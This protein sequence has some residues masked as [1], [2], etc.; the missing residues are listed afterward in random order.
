MGLHKVQDRFLKRKKKQIFKNCDHDRGFCNCR[1]K[2]H[3][4]IKKVKANI[5]KQYLELTWK[6]LDHPQIQQDKKNIK[7]Y[8]KNIEKFY[9]RGFGI[10]LHGQPGLG[11]TTLGTFILGAAIKKGFEVHYIEFQEALDLYTAKWNKSGIEKE[12][13]ENKFNKKI[14]YRDFLLLDNLGRETRTKINLKAL[15][16]IIRFR[17]NNGLPTIFTSNLSIKKFCNRY[18]N[19]YKNNNG[20]V[21][22]SLLSSSVKT[23]KLEGFDYRR[24]VL[25]A[26]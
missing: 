22:F 10:W 1:K 17:T 3:I 21:L 23:V 14:L 12:N 26:D 6:D 19:N 4:L 15:E 9:D 24:K 2:F 18:G 20:D 8:V 11:K 16:K 7:K 25:K 13:I 5:P